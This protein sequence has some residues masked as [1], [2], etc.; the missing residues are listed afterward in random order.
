[1]PAV[2]ILGVL[3]FAA[4]LPDSGALFIG[5]H[6]KNKQP[7]DAQQPQE[8]PGHVVPFMGDGKTDAYPEKRRTQE[9]R[10]NGPNECRARSFDIELSLE[11]PTNDQK[12]DARQ[13]KYERQQLVGTTPTFE[14]VHFV[15]QFVLSGGR[16]GE[17]RP[18]GVGDEGR[19][20]E[21]AFDGFAQRTFGNVLGLV[22]FG[23]NN[24]GVHGD[25]LH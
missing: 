16:H 4:N 23:T 6:G 10:Q 12:P 11:N 22:A 24:L 9:R 18:L 19:A 20:A 25:G 2:F 8:R 15:N 17:K 14:R 21:T 13:A 5:K 3:K 7:A 1:V